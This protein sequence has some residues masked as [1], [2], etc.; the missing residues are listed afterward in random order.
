MMLLW[1]IPDQPATEPASEMS[2]QDMQNLPD[3]TLISATSDTDESSLISGAPPASLQALPDFTESKIRKNSSA[4]QTLRNSGFSARETH[5]VIDAAKEVRDLSKVRAGM[6]LRIYPRVAEK[7]EEQD[8]FSRVSFLLSMTD[9]LNIMKQADGSWTGSIHS[10]P[11]SVQTEAY[12]G[13]IRASLWQSATAAGMDAE[14][15]YAL[16][17]IF[18]W[19]I[20]F[21]REVRPGDSWRVLLNRKYVEGTPLSWEPVIM[22]EYH[23]VSGNHYTAIRYPPEGEPAEY[24]SPEGDN[25][26]GRFLKSPLRYSR[27]SSGFQLRRFHPVLGIH[28]PHY[29]V[30]YAAP[31]GTPVRAVGDGT[32][33]IIGRRGGNGRMIRIRHNAVYET[34]YKHLSR[35]AS[36]LR[37][38]SNVQ[39]GDI[40]G[41]VGS[42]GLATG[43]H[44]HF[45]FYENS[46]FTDPLGRKFPREDPVAPADK[47]AF[48][49]FVQ[50]SRRQLDRLQ[51]STIARKDATEDRQPEADDRF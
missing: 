31:T 50:E 17:D 8:D 21:S 48:L 20:D 6:I 16:S 37:R 19:Q 39:Q 42:S 47:D 15:V 43:P 46:R 27:I 33:T 9:T 45:E 5:A 4:Y 25:L 44:L 14:P 10:K 12:Q 35:Y 2:G 11:V 29:G 28:R 13:E 1:L 22:A 24:Y 32:I 23:S 3:D 7:P 51:P 38:G 18:A 40:I 26:R 30:D 36:G 41:Y 34:A 49:Q